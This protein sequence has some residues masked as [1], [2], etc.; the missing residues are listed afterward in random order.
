MALQLYYAPTIAEGIQI[1][2]LELA[3]H[4]ANV[5]RMRLGD[6]FLITNGNGLHGTATIQEISKK[7]TVVNISNLQQTANA[8]PAINLA[9]AFTK[10]ASRM[11]WMLEK[12]TEIGVTNIYPIVTERTEK[13]HFKKERFQ[14]ILESAMCQSM[15][16]F[17]PVL[18]EPIAFN[19]LVETKNSELKCIAHC[20][21][22]EEKKTLHNVVQNTKSTLICIGPEGDFTPTEIEL[23]LAKNYLPVSLGATRLR[24][25]TAG[26]VAITL[27][28][29]LAHR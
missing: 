19:K 1:L 18:H 2:P 10:N 24:T 14:K 6:L 13:T 22:N 7:Q 9:I 20:I 26:M 5:L 3:H 4:L 15:Q 16:Y 8:N 11:E 21:D 28:N 29:N 12:I 25:E 23:C 27:L 17:L